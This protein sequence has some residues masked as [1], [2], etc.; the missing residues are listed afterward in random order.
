MSFGDIFK[1]SFLDGFT[2]TQITTKTIIVALA[3][4]LC[5]GLYMFVVY[6]LTN[7]N[8]LYNVNFNISLVALTLIT[9]GVILTIQS[10]VVVSLGMVG[11]LSI[12]RFRTAVKDPMDLVYLFWSIGVGIM[13]GAIQFE[14]AMLVSV[15]V[16]ITIIGIQFLPKASESKVL[17]V[18]SKKPELA[19]NYITTIKEWTGYFKV[20]AH[21]IR[22]TGLEIIVECRTKKG[23]E[24]VQAVREMDG[25]EFVSL[26]SHDGGMSY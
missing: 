21:N 24:L 14:I 15:V 19:E 12:V 25:V 18:R 23:V 7:R 22:N 5:M 26:M 10:S 20:K 3:I 16:T 9:A 13:C 11:A 8:S 4:A 1:Q 6:A 17:I 2:V